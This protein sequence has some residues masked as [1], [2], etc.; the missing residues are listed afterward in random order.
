MN[1]KC[2]LNLNLYNKIFYKFDISLYNVYKLHNI[3]LAFNF[4]I[5]NFFNIYNLQISILNGNQVNF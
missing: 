5:E 2:M 4:I 1:S 3:I